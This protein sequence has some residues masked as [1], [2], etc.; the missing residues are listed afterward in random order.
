MLED[1][2][3]ADLARAYKL[4]RRV[5]APSRAAVIRRDDGGA[6]QGEADAARPRARARPHPRRPARARAQGRGQQLVQDDEKKGDPVKYA[7]ALLSLRDKYQA[8][9]EEAFE[10][11]KSFLNALNGAFES[12]VNDNAQSPR[13]HLALCRRPAAQGLKGTSRTTWSGCSTR[14]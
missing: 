1:S 14:W 12:F 2:K 8:I 4:Y 7:R 6:R 13:V 5:T 10:G 9:I 3:V 11:D